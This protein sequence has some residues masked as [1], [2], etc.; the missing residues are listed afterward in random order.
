Q[1]ENEEAMAAIAHGLGLAPGR[2]D[3]LAIRAEVEQWSGDLEASFATLDQASQA[4]PDDLEILYATYQAA[5][6]VPT[7]ETEV[8]ADRVLSRLAELRP[9]NVV[10][11][12]QLGQ[13]A[14]ARGDRATATGAFARVREL[15]WQG[16]E[17]SHRALAMVVD[18]LEED[19]LSAVR[20]PAV[21]LENVLKVSAMFRES[22]RELRTGIQGIPIA[23]FENE[24]A[25]SDFGP[26]VEVSFTAHALDGTAT[27]GQALVA[28]DL[29]SDGRADLARILA[30]GELEIRLAAK[31]WAAMLVRDPDSPEPAELAAP[32]AGGPASPDGAAP[33]A[34]APETQA[35][36]GAGQ[37]ASFDRLLALDL[38]ND[39]HLDLLA[40][41][42]AAMRL[43]LGAGDGTFTRAEGDLGLSQAGALDLAAIDFDIEGDL[44]LALVGGASGPADL[45]RNNLAGPL[46]RVGTK[47]LP[48][49]PESLPRSV[50]PSDLD[51]D[52]DLD[53][54]IGHGRGL[55]W[56]DNLRQGRFRDRSALAG[57]EPGEAVADVVAVDLDGDG[58]P[59]P[60]ATSAGAETERSL[61]FWRNTGTKLLPW[62][63]SPWPAE[64]MPAG[65]FTSLVPFDADNDGRMDLAAA[66]PG[67]V[68]VLTQVAS[69]PGEVGFRVSKVEGAPSP[70]SVV[71]P[72]DLDGDG[73]LDLAVGSPAGLA[74]LEN[75][76]AEEQ[77]WLALRLRGLDRGSSKNNT[78]GVGSVVEVRVGTAYQYHEARG[79]VV[80]VGLGRHPKAAVVRV[81]W[82]NGV[83]QNRIDLEGNRTGVEEQL[84]KGSCPF[85]YAWD[86]ERFTFVTDLL[87][88]APIGLPAAPGV[89]VSSD[90]SELVRVDGLVADDSGRYRLRITEELWEA[91]FFDYL[92]LW[93]VDHPADVEVASDLRIV[94]GRASEEKVLGSRDL[95][96]LR[97][98]WDGR[99]R[100]VTER[101]AR[102]D[103][104]YADGYT[105][106]PYQGVAEPWTFTFDLG[107][108]PSAPVRLHLAGW[109]FPAD[110]SLNLAVA[111]RDDY[112]YLAPRLEV[113]TPEGWKPLMDDFGFPAGKTKTL[114]VDLPPLPAGATRLRLVTS[115]WL[116]WDRIAWTTSP[117]D[118]EPRIRA[119]LAPDVADLRFRGFSAMERRAPN[120]PH[121]FDYHR[122]RIDSPWLP[123]PGSYTRYGAVG[124]LLEEVD[125]FSVIL[126][127]GDEL[128][129]EFDASS[130]EP[131]PA[132]WRRTL[133]LESHGWDKDA[134][135]NT[136][137]G[138]TLEPLPFRAMSAYPFA[139]GETYPDTPDH[140][141]YRRDWLTREIR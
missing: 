70:A 57:L 31:G 108:T 140:R 87:W 122:A 125:D 4:A 80:H 9:E 42:P 123:F 22:L 65:P 59:D 97:A 20:V 124:P 53:L 107:E 7:A 63:P 121:V 62:T 71:V 128:A 109:I 105:P 43:W 130:L 100:E 138:S 39:G 3:L 58:F 85:L 133:M 96:P 127:A 19:D 119:R 78:L 23:R 114:V 115:L 28:G 131:P 16:P 84:L 111:Q 1:Q 44:D 135:R 34:V 110:A 126:A 32:D 113:E 98:A 74:W 45:W 40:A 94:P 29:D 104:V 118:D 91:A 10:V 41:G 106:S 17:I 95:R 81:V 48:R 35:E 139:A 51:R 30:S 54:L 93:V 26:P 99:G 72:V 14:V 136:G 6:T 112:P 117:A 103:D 64:S 83:P 141:R 137:E 116:H 24:P 49:L 79:D 69:G 90:A 8:V 56:L 129:L 50:W 12:L 25:P 15:L 66:G 33:A 67:G 2:A 37:P 38:D 11:L 47:A 36:A 21:R 77:H 76:G 18:A 86:G 75:R 13:R 68:V 89:W 88:G 134:D 101:V 82:T 60:V 92:R 120:A 52:G 27:A 55:Q 132:G 46:E 73:D 61:R 102:R 5:T